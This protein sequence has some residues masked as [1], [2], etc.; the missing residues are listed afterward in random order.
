MR[1]RLIPIKPGCQVPVPVLVC[2]PW[3]REHTLTSPRHMCWGVPFS[4]VKVYID[5]NCL[6]IC[7]LDIFSYRAR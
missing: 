5:W 2:Q 3:L 4:L 7:L 6:C 1:N